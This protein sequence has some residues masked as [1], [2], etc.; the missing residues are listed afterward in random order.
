MPYILSED[1][2]AQI[3]LMFTNGTKLEGI[4]KV[5]DDNKV[6]KGE[7][8]ASGSQAATPSPVPWVGP[9]NL[10]TIPMSSLDVLKSK[11]DSLQKT[12][13]ALLAMEK[14][15]RMPEFAGAVDL[16]SKQTQSVRM[17][18]Y[19]LNNLSPRKEAEIV[20]P[21]TPGFIK[22]TIQADNRT[23]LEGPTSK[24]ARQSPLAIPGSNGHSPLRKPDT[25]STGSKLQNS[26]KAS[27]A[28]EN[29]VPVAPRPSEP[30]RQ[31][32]N[33]VIRAA[34]EHNSRVSK[35]TKSRPAAAPHTPLHNRLTSALAKITDRR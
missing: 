31:I 13:D 34:S 27:P 11:A 21:T 24:D 30:P 19:R 1:M 29:R 8:T 33:T 5:L 14:V 4:K 20:K 28:A 23:I 2:L 18:I 10:R 9:N 6:H 12:V 25:V 7:S 3:G 22:N 35:E 26:A 17:E 32:G 16:V 15:R